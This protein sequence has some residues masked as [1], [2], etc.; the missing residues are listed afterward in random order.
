MTQELRNLL[1]NACT[2]DAA[3]HGTCWGER[4]NGAPWS[5][6]LELRAPGDHLLFKRKMQWEEYKEAVA[7]YLALR[8]QRRDSP[9]HTTRRKPYRR[10]RAA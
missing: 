4:Q 9:K 1:K 2:L 3:M 5:Y 6:R 8:A 10:K 7:Y